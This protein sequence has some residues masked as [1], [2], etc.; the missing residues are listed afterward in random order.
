MP[1]V[2]IPTTGQIYVVASVIP[3][4]INVRVVDGGSITRREFNYSVLMWGDDPQKVKDEWVTRAPVDGAVAVF[5]VPSWKVGPMS[6]MWLAMAAEEDEDE[7]ITNLD[8]SQVFVTFMDHLDKHYANFIQ[9][10]NCGGTGYSGYVSPNLRCRH[11]DGEG[12][13]HVYDFD[14]RGVPKA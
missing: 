2:S 14:G 9:C 12:G 11:C 5:G 10:D 3:K 7:Q 1:H 8:M 4:V 13:T 6:V